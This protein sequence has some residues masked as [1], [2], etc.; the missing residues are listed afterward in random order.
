M[1]DLPT[2]PVRDILGQTIGEF[3]LEAAA[4]GAKRIIR[5]ITLAGETGAVLVLSLGQED[6]EM[7]MR[8]L[9]SV[10]EPE[11]DHSNPAKEQAASDSSETPE[12]S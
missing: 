11:Q 6:A 3:I 4:M 8:A 9:C 1:K 10:K 5:P 7:V 12:R 2:R